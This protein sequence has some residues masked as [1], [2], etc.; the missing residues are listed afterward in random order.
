MVAFKSVLRG[1]GKLSVDEAN[2]APISIVRG[3]VLGE[4]V[5]TVM[6][7]AGHENPYEAEELTRGAHHRRD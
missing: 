1:V 7:K 6:R 5:Q 2:C 3:E 4:A